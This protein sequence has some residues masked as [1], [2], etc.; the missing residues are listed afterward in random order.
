VVGLWR[1][2]QPFH[3][4]RILMGPRSEVAE[5]PL[6]SHSCCLGFFFS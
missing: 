3:L 2:L 6:H 1:A 4:V 5:I